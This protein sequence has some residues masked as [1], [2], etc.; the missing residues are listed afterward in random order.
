[1][2]LSRNTPE[3]LIGKLGYLAGLNPSAKPRTLKSLLKE[4]DWKRVPK[5]NIFVPAGLFF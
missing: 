2:L 5:E 1:L 4:F 3:E